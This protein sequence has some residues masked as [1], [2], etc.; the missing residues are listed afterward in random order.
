MEPMLDPQHRDLEEA[1]LRAGREVS[2]SSEL[3]AKTLSAIGLTAAAAG[4]V[5]ATKV[6]FLSGKVGALSTAGFVGAVGLIGA[7]MFVGGETKPNSAESQTTESS[8]REV[9][10]PEPAID[11]KTT[12]SE[13]SP[14]INP[15][16]TTDRQA[17][18][19]AQT[20]ANQ[21]AT[22]GRQTSFSPQNANLPVQTGLRDE[23]S[24]IAQ[25]E[26]ALKSG[27]YSQALALLS[28]YRTRFS[29]PQLGLEAEVLTIQA[30]YKSGSKAGAQKRAQRFLDRHPKSP[31]GAQVKLY[32][33]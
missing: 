33:K 8:G 22:P 31:L 5:A 3:Q 20:T 11:Q 16:T 9:S 17:I 6:S 28:E 13:S 24:Q 27:Q 12:T 4:T 7:V 1:L 25:A 23:L 14:I 2:M 32:L 29:H 30:L 18:V 15:P 26:A 10:L 19:D 21:L